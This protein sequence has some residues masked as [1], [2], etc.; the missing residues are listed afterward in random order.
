MGHEYSRRDFPAA[1]DR[2]NETSGR[3]GLKVQTRPSSLSGDSSGSITGFF[4]VLVLTSLP[5][6]VGH[7]N[8]RERSARNAT[9]KMLSDHA[10]K[11][12]RSSRTFHQD[13]DNNKPN[14]RFR[15]RFD[16]HLPLWRL[17][18]PGAAGTGDPQT[19]SSTGVLW[20]PPTCQPRPAQRSRFPLPARPMKRPKTNEQRATKVKRTNTLPLGKVVRSSK[21]EKTLEILFRPL[22]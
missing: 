10:K 20:L 3:G 22:P 13:T 6:S 9:Q 8:S 12:S 19:I 2:R 14:R 15:M 5:V 16:V 7:V 1:I 11:K 17:G 18:T 21:R 4:L